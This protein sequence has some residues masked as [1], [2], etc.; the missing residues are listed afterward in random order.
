MSHGTAGIA[1]SLLKVAALTCEPRYHETAMQAWRYE[2]SLYDATAGQWRDL[3]TTVGETA[4]FTCAWCHGAPGIGL[5]RLASLDYVDDGDVRRDIERAVAAT[6]SEGFDMNHCLCHGAL[7]NLELPMIGARE[8]R[9]SASRRVLDR[10]DWIAASDEAFARITR[11]LAH[12]GPVCGSLAGLESPGFMTGLAG[13]GYQ[14]LRLSNPDDVPSV[15]TL[16]PPV[17]ATN[18]RGGSPR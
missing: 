5:A 15:L 9:T 2:R 16:S 10:P 3:R 17:M 7:G 11:D 12:R 6:L 13:V 18:G 4:S 8:A 1:L 14:L